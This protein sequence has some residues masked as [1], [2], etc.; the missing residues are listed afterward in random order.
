M[1]AGLPV[2]QLAKPNWKHVVLHHNDTVA[3][4]K[5]NL[6]IIKRETCLKEN[7]NN[8]SHSTLFY[9]LMQDK[10]SDEV[11]NFLKNNLHFLL[12]M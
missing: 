12:L 1:S 2:C 10:S 7:K 8:D 5:P 3:Y 11:E 6:K 9:Y 4:A